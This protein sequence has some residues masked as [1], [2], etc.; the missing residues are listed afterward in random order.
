MKK[1]YVIGLI[2]IVYLLAKLYVMQTETK[3]DDQLPD[4]VRDIAV[5]VFA[6]DDP[7]FNPA[8][9]HQTP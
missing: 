1:R 5:Q 9:T 8:E 4:A 7:N 6:D 2:A 3:L